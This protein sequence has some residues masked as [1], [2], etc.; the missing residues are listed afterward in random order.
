[1]FKGVCFGD[2]V[3]HLEVLNVWLVFVFNLF[4][5]RYSLLYVQNVAEVK[6]CLHVTSF[7]MF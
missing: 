4:N 5:S 2:D 7:R 1:M 6:I 3:V